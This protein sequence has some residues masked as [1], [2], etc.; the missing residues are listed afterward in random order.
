VPLSDIRAA[1]AATIT[2]V[3][4]VGSA[5]VV[6][7]Q[8]QRWA[9]DWSRV[10]ELFKGDGDRIHA[11]MVTRKRTP[12]KRDNLPTMQR[13]HHFR[14]MGIYGVKDAAASELVFQDLVENVSIALD[15]NPTLNGTVLDSG[16]TQIDDVDVRA[17]GK[18]LCHVAELSLDAHERRLY[19]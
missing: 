17:F 12:V 4:G 11:W 7:H 18:I 9:A 3:E 13:L 15:N 10:L 6:V 8:Y 5:G 19:A 2:A 16:P 1:V 14:I